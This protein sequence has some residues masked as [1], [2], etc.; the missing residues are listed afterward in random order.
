[1]AISVWC[2]WKNFHSPGPDEDCWAYQRSKIQSRRVYVTL[3]SWRDL[4]KRQLMGW[5]WRRALWDQRHEVDY[6]LKGELHWPDSS[7]IFRGLSCNRTT[8]K[9]W[10]LP[11]HW[12]GHDK[13]WTT[14]RIRKFNCRN[15]WDELLNADRAKIRGSGP[16]GRRLWRQWLRSAATVAVIEERLVYIVSARLMANANHLITLHCNVSSRTV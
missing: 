4:L 5:F 10:S 13:Q 1:M 8:S 12:R 3:Q 7:S 11:R 15:E 6:T 2:I 14:G 16:N 9:E